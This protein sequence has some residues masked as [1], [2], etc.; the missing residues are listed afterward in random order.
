MQAE[1][2]WGHSLR[3]YMRDYNHWT[4]LGLLCELMPQPENR[5]TLADERDQY[6]MPVA[7]FTHS[8][9]DNDKRNIAYA[10][11]VLQE[12]WA[13]RGGPRH[14]EDR[15]LRP[16][17]RRRADG[18]LPPRTASSMPAI[19]SGGSQT[20]SCAT[21]ACFPPKARPTRRW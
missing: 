18:V 4:V 8:L 15:P 3:E 19:A 17:R 9:C 21:A 7:N 12:I 5:V 14:A 6:G 2:H 16:P 11:N 1:G 13:G 20:C 10:T